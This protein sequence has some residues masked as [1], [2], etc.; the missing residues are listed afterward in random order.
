MHQTLL[1][2][3]RH[4]KP[5]A[6]ARANSQAM[7]S[8]GQSIVTGFRSSTRDTRARRRSGTHAAFF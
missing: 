2:K 5:R 3:E 7:T 4:G 6:Q 8:K 1:E